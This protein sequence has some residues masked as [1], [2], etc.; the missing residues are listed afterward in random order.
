MRLKSVVYGFKYQHLHTGWTFFTFIW[1]KNCN[2]WKDENKWKR[3]RGWPILKISFRV[4][5]WLEPEEALERDG[6]S[7]CQTLKNEWYIIPNLNLN[8]SL[9]FLK[10]GVL[11]QNI[12]HS[13]CSLFCVWDTSTLIEWLCLV[14]FSGKQRNRT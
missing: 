5:F 11:N 7:I 10:S 2:V 12:A 3:G 4:F 6:T 13:M 9:K 1:C 14:W 8:F